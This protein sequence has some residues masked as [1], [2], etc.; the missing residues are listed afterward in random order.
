[1]DNKIKISSIIYVKN[2]LPY[3]KESVQSVVAQ[4]LQEIE[5]LIVDGGSTDGTREYLEEMRIRDPRILILDSAPSVGA[6]FNLALSVAKGEYIAIC[7][8]DDYILPDAYE[9]LFFYAKQSACDVIR[10]DYYQFYGAGENEYRFLTHACSNP[11]M[12][13]L[14]IEVEDD[15]FV[16]EGINGFW[17]GLYRRGFLLENGIYMNET[18]GASYQDVSFSFLTQ[19]YAQKIYFLDKPFYCYRLD[20]PN[21]SMNATNRTA[22]MIN[23]FKLL[24]KRLK[25]SKVWE[26]IYTEFFLWELIG[27]KRAYIS[28]VSEQKQEIINQITEEIKKQL[29]ENC[30][31]WWTLGIETELQMYL[32]DQDIEIKRLFEYMS[33][34][35][36]VETVAVFGVGFLGQ[37]TKKV[38]Q[39]I[40]REDYLLVDNSVSLQ[41]T[42]IDG[43]V[44]YSPYEVNEKYPDAIYLIANVVHANE[45]KEQ[46][47]QMNVSPQHI[48]FSNNDDILLRRVLI[49][50]VR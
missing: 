1:M 20:N 15:F 18:P 39:A 29:S 41:G 38:L 37:V 10:S 31:E 28:A 36:S 34:Q 11:N 49:N 48:F 14:N 46:L 32:T 9:E 40:N 2:G 19:F 47:I 8:A 44:V 33:Q 21:A 26:L 45:I 25:E 7:E 4:T 6:Q 17:N 50:H 5:I 22:K 12:Y 43:H 13:Y 27:L 16:K 3:I 35:P 42:K 23:E 30:V 24:E